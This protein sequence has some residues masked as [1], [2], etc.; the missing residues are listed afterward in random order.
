M[1]VKL[2][3]IISMSNL[4]PYFSL[5]ITLVEMNPCL[6]SP[7]KCFRTVVISIYSLFYFIWVF[8]ML[9]YGLYIVVFLVYSGMWYF[10]PRSIEAC[11]WFYRLLTSC[12]SSF[13]VVFLGW[14]VWCLLVSFFFRTDTGHFQYF[15]NTSCEF[16][17]FFIALEW[18]AV[19]V[20]VG[21]HFLTTVWHFTC[22]T[23][24]WN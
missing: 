8:C 9:I 22:K 13:V 23:Q 20:D 14:P 18:H 10:C 5:S 7:L 3:G 16:S 1:S 2:L 19:C 12:L 15:W 11:S 17:P 21:L 6:I 24:S 4:S